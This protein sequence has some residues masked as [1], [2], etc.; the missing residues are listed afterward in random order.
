MFYDIIKTL[1]KDKSVK[2][3]PLLK[4][5]GLS[6][7][8]ISRWRGGAMPNGKTLT[9]LAGYFGVTTDFLLGSEA[10]SAS[11]VIK[12]DELQFALYKE[13]QDLTENDKRDVLEFARY[14]KEKRRKEGR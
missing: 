7:S 9:K 13:T 6:E 10:L 8:G 1:C 14:I 11:D 2:L 4:E 12:L 3:T 5:L